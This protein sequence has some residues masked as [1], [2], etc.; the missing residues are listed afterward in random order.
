M[1]NQAHNQGQNQAQQ[2]RRVVVIQGETS[3][4]TTLVDLPPDALAEPKA[5][6]KRKAP[7][8]A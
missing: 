8:K 3:G 7:P 5:K 6:A 1:P 4:K 2:K